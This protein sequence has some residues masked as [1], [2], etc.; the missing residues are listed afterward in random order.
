M[1]GRVKQTSDLAVILPI[2]LGVSVVQAQDVGGP[3]A[4]SGAAPAG[5]VE[6]SPATASTTHVYVPPAGV[7]GPGVNINSNLP[8]SSQPITDASGSSDTFDLAPSVGGNG[9]MSGAAEGTAVFGKPRTKMTAQMP[10]IHTVRQG[11]TLWGLCEGYFDDPWAWPKLWSF[12]PQIQNPHWIYP[13]D[14]VRLKTS[15]Q[16]VIGGDRSLTRGA[17]GIGGSG[18]GAPKF[19]VQLRNI[20][21]LD[22]P[23]REKWGEVV[24]AREDRM[25]LGDESHLYLMFRQ[26]A[27][28]KLGQELTVYRGIR[29]SDSAPGA[30]KPPGEV[31]KIQGLVRIDQWNPET[32]VAQASVLESAD[33][34]ERGAFVGPLGNE[35]EMVAPKPSEQEHWVRVIGSVYPHVF[36]A[37]EQVVFIDRGSE[38]GIEPGNRLFVVRRGDSWRRSLSDSISMARD[39]I[40]SESSEPV[41]VE[42]TPLKGNEQ[43]FPEEQIAELRVLRSQKFSS[44]AI[45]ISSSREIVAGDRAVSRKGL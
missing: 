3:D 14:Q 7:P 17:K 32:R 2:L 44:V 28:V 31:I 18:D 24:G 8:S 25:L 30:R 27:P 42:V 35:L 20:G 40:L 5:S 9:T 13:G 34:I 23:E 26:D 45:V 21:F 43:D 6:V 22:N 1:R 4:P 19:A 15:G 39:R 38:D 10:E 11:D 33:P 29:P 37:S 36:M 41:M 16:S 12:N